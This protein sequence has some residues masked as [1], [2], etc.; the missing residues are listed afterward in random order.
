MKTDYSPRIGFSMY[1]WVLVIV[2]ITGFISWYQYGFKKHFP[3]PV[4]ATVS[5]DVQLQMD[6]HFFT[7]EVK[8]GERVTILASEDNE[9][10]W[11]ETSDHMRGFLNLEDVQEWKTITNRED[12][13]KYQVVR[14]NYIILTEAQMQK[15]YLGHTFEENEN[16]YWPARYRLNK[17]NVTYAT[18]QIRM[19]DGERFMMPTVRYENDTAV[20]VQR[21]SEVPVEGNENWLRAVPWIELLFSTSFFHF[22]W[23]RPMIQSQKSWIDNWWWI[24]KY[25][26]KAIWFLIS[27]FIY[28]CWIAMVFNQF[29]IPFLCLVPLR[30][31]FWHLPNFVL[32][33]LM[34]I[35]SAFGC[36]FFMPF[37][38]LNHGGLMTI[39][40]MFLAFICGLDIIIATLMNRCKKCRCF[41]FIKEI[42]RE[43]DHTEYKDTGRKGT[44]VMGDGKTPIEYAI[45]KKIEH[46]T[47]YCICGICGEVS[48]RK[49]TKET[50][51]RWEDGPKKYREALESIK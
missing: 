29:V 2:L 26:L 42:S 17:E 37:L 41:G 11:V 39:I 27:L 9:R 33:A 46:Y 47:I 45:L 40:I 23:D 3:E 51:L 6:N 21:Y 44:S 31:P 28:V 34:A 19:W 30:Y 14:K 12:I 10:F 18:Y 50:E 15:K 8:K 25:P 24:F 38:L 1:I 32:G 48:V 43:L 36:Y 5:Q 35:I 13:E 49:D 7:H 20:A 4:V 16:I 22:H